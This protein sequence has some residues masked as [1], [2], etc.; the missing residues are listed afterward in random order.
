MEFTFEL[1]IESAQKN[2]LVLRKYG[3]NLEKALA[4]QKGTPLEYSSEFRTADELA[5]IFQ[6]HPLWESMKENLNTGVIFPLEKLDEETRLLDF[7]T[8]LERGN[9][10][11]AQKKPDLLRELISK[12]M[13]HGYGLPLPLSMLIRIPSTVLAPMN[14]MAQNTIN[15]FGQ[16]IA[17]DRLTHNQ[18]FDF[19]P[20]SSVSSRVIWD[21]LPPVRYG[22]C[23]RRIIN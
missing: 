4:V 14:I 2:F 12:D 22:H 13:I 17:K 23:M 19:S 5:P 11:G 8:A 16:I 21:N 3:F 7:V 9:H 10:K 6:D 1:T 15:E 20:D 18:S